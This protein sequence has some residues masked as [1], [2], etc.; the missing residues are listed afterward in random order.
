MRN[1]LMSAPDND[2]AI[3]LGDGDW[4]SMSDFGEADDAFFFEEEE[5]DQGAL[6]RR[7]PNADLALV[8]VLQ[9]LVEAAR[10]FHDATGKYLQV[11]GDIGEL[12]GAIMYGIALHKDYAQGSDGRLG[13]DF[14]EIKTISPFNNHDRVCVRLDRHFSKLLVVKVYPNFSIGGRMKRRKDLP[15]RNGNILRLKWDSL[16]DKCQEKFPREFW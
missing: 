13:N 10:S 8:P 4:L 15:R 16:E 2:D 3:Y 5:A 1:T 14:I 9:G 12:F 11:F 7:F 6:Q